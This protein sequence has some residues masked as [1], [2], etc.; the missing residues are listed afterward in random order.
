M[1]FVTAAHVLQVLCIYSLEFTALLSMRGGWGE[2]GG[3]APQLSSGLNT[4]LFTIW[5]VHPSSVWGPEQVRDLWYG[6][7]VLYFLA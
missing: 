1:G 5:E 7:C 3:R 2:W 6:R 4:E